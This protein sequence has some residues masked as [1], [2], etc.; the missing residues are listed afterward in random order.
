MKSNE[1]L[2]ALMILDYVVYLQQSKIDLENDV[3]SFSQAMEV[4]RCYKIRLKL[5]DDI[6]V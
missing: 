6:E 3:V 1:D 2:L 4:V 5:I